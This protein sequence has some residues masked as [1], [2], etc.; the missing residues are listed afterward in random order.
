MRHIQAATV[1]SPE[2]AAPRTLQPSIGRLSQTN[3]TP[4][5]SWAWSAILRLCTF[6]ASRGFDTFLF[7]SFDLIESLIW[8]HRG[9]LPWLVSFSVCHHDPE[10]WPEPSN[11]DVL[12]W[13]L[14]VQIGKIFHHPDPEGIARIIKYG[15][16][17]PRLYFNYATERTTMWDSAALKRKYRYEVVFRPDTDPAL[18]LIL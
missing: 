12:R 13:F 6:G 10:W 2:N 11:S 18:E 5:K 3:G 15:G 1:S 7:R 8:L 9:F 17:N 4:P 16:P 14:S